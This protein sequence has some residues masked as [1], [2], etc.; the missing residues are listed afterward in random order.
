MAKGYQ[1]VECPCTDV[2]IKNLPI[3]FQFMA[4]SWLVS[5][6]R[7]QVSIDKLPIE[8]DV[9]RVQYVSRYLGIGVHYPQS[10]LVDYGEYIE[11]YAEEIIKTCSFIGFATLNYKLLK[12]DIIDTQKWNDD[13]N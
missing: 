8:V 4:F 2:L 3:D 1:I 13:I 6:L 12:D 11:S 9:I 5:L 10:K 7:Q